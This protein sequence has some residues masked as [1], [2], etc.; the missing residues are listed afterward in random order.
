MACKGLGEYKE[1]LWVMEGR[2]GVRQGPFC[3]MAGAAHKTQ[4]D[5]M[6]MKLPCIN[7]YSCQATGIL[8]CS[9]IP[10]YFDTIF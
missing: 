3:D 1:D 6:C 7:S 8:T 2:S 9:C 4:A 5:T 10:A